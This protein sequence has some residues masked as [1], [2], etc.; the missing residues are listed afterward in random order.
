MQETTL[1]CRGLA[2]PEPVLRVKKT[3]EAHSPNEITILV[4]NDAARENVS[5]FLQSVG[6]SAI[7]SPAGQGVWQVTGKKDQTAVS[8]ASCACRVPVREGRRVAVL[9]T[10]PV[11]GSGDDTLGEK[12]MKNF[13]ATLPEMG[14]ELW[15]VVM[16]NGAVTLSLANSPVLEQ[17]QTL[18]KNGVHI[19]VCGTCL[20]HFGVLRE[21]AVGE[22]TNMLDVVTS[23]QLADSVIRP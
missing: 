12:L 23:L 15:R 20:E 5:R 10:S 21:K 2:C 3:V 17:L 7:D 18:E 6:Y 11:I 13:L 19:L 22:T 14:S 8:V 4:D 9:L 16:L 1:D